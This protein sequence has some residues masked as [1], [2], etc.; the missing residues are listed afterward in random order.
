MS[1]SLFQ[2]RLAAARLNDEL[3]RELRDSED[4]EDELTWAT[5]PGDSRKLR[6][7]PAVGRGVD[8]SIPGTD[9]VAALEAK[10]PD[11]DAA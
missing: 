8:G 3:L 5:A 7:I 4:V 9:P 11:E 10:Y 2:A 6:G 1:K